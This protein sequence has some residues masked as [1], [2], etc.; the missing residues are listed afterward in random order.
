MAEHKIEDTNPPVARRAVRPF[1]GPAG[2]AAPARPLLRPTGPVGRPSPAPF[3]PPLATPRPAL[4]TMANATPAAPATDATMSEAVAP[5]EPPEPSQ[6]PSLE[7]ESR[8]P[9]TSEMVALDTFA[10]FDAV[11]G[12]S[13]TPAA[14]P[15]VEPV[16]S[17]IDE[18]SLGSGAGAH[19]LWAED[20]TAAE[21]DATLAVEEPSGP[22]AATERGVAPSDTIDG[23]WPTI[24]TP[25][26][27][28]PAWLVDDPTELSPP[29]QPSSDLVVAEA[30]DNLADQRDEAVDAR[31]AHGLR[32][33][34]VL[35]R[36]AARVRGGEID[37]SSVAPEAP[38]AAVLASVLAALLGGSSSR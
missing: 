13:T 18:A 34:A 37:I 7:P 33:S 6:L 19:E 26:S 36:L 16:T 35:D 14:S 28:M 32:V 30:N 1:V 2:A 3:A 8:P 29:R 27:A 31:A 20:I 24:T 22:A 5:V 21:L 23:G 25:S 15:L 10:A 12:R 4:G 9:I 17:P 38:D 11:W